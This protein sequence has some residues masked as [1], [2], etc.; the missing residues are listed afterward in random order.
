MNPPD[1]HASSTLNVNRPAANTSDDR[2]AETLPPAARTSRFALTM[3]WWGI[4]SAMFYL[5]IG[6]TLALNFGTANA[7]IGMSLAVV[8]FGIIT[9]VLARHAVRTG[10]SS[11]VLSLTMFGRKG[12]AIPTL[13]LCAT[14]LYYAVFEGSVLAVAASKVLPGV[15]YETAVVLVA[16]YSAP[17]SIG[18]V[19]N[20]FDKLN[21]FLLPFYLT[22]LVLLV[23][24]TIGN[25]G[26]SSA[27]LAI[28]PVHTPPPG[29]WWDCFV[30]YLGMMVMAMVA[31]DFARFG[32][33]EDESYHALFNFG[34]PFYSVTILVSG[35]VAIFLIG[36]LG[37]AQVTETSVVD[38]CLTVLGA[39]AG[40][41]WV[42]VTQTRINTANY[43][44][45]TVN[46]QAF[47]EETLNCRLPKT[48][49]AAIVG[50]ASLLLM[51]STNVFGYIVTALNYQGVFINAWIGVALAH[52]L[53][54]ASR[55]AR[56]TTVPNGHENS[57]H[58]PGL[59]AW[60]AGVVAGLAAMWSGSA[61]ASMS[62]PVTLAVSAICYYFGG[63]RNALSP[64]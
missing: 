30:A 45:S 32:R 9:G 43:Y 27:W 16:L 19:Q 41:A 35:I 55:G 49:C 12:G 61:A 60:S 33:R 42:F 64:R 6:A 1:E 28:G 15:S 58:M 23:G 54:E 51:E 59:V 26:Y 50:V 38:A 10:S 39:E 18:S 7:L 44:V 22:G 46:L 3:A 11:S 2:A 21:G 63:G 52:V 29:A 48:V 17:L 34:V 31:M 25:Q 53:G 13:I 62:A 36:S 14:G 37:T 5:F 4:C 40:L 8:A 20:F 47:L 57:Y 24:L 56:A